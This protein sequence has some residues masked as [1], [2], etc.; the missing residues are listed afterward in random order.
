MLSRSRCF[1]RLFCN[2]I[3]KYQ[4]QNHRENILLRPDS[5]IGSTKEVTC[6]QFLYNDNISQ[7]IKCK[8]SY[9]PGFLKIFDEI[10]VNAADNKQRDPNM[11]RIDISI[12]D[13]N[14]IVVRN[15][16]K[17]IPIQ[18]QPSMNVYIPTLVMGHLLT[19]SNYDDNKKRIVG[20]R[21]GYGAK[22]CN[23]YSKQF[24]ITCF[25]SKE[26]KKFSQTWYDNMS[27]SDPPIIKDIDFLENED[28][29]E[30][31]FIPDLQRF[32]M[33]SI[34]DDVV[35]ILKKRAFDLAG[36][37]NG[38]KVSFNGELINVS[39]FEDYVKLHLSE[40]KETLK[41]F[42]TDRWEIYISQSTSGFEQVS[43][44][45]NIV[46]RIGGS[47]VDYI[48]NQIISHIVNLLKDKIDLTRIRSFH[49]KNHINIFIKC[50][51]ENPSFN[52]QTKEQL[53]SRVSEF[54][55]MCIIPQTF[56]S[57]F[58][59]TSTIPE[60]ILS[61]QKILPS[62][63]EI[64]NKKVFLSKLE[65]ALHAGTNNSSK[66]SLFLTEGDSAK[67]LVVSGFSV[68]G[69]DFYGVF[70]L[71]GKSINARNLSFEDCIKNVEFQ[72]IIKIINLKKN[73]DYS[74]ASNRN[75]LRYGRII[76]F[77][78][79]DLDGIHIKGLVINMFHKFW[80]ELVESGFI[81]TL[82]T[83]L[84]KVRCKGETINFYNKFEFDEWLN[85]SKKKEDFLNY[86][87][88]YYKGLGTSTKEEAKEY[89][90][91]IEKNL[92][93]Y[94]CTNEED[95]LSIK[96][97]FNKNLTFDRKVMIQNYLPSNTSNGNFLSIADFAKNELAE[98]FKYDIK[99]SIPSVVDGLKESQ[100]KIIY[101]MFSKF[102]K[103]EI[104]VNQLSG[105]TAH[106]TLYRHGE[107]FLIS[108]IVKMAQNFVGTGNINLL[109]PI[110]QFGTRAC[111][112][113]DSASGRYIHTSLNPL[114]RLLFPKEDDKLLKYIEEEN[115]IIEPVYYVPIIPTILVN[116]G[117]G[118]AT[119]WS[120]SIF[121]YNPTDII[122]NIRL[123]INGKEPI[124]M[125]PYYRNFKGTIVET[126]KKGTYNINGL[127][128]VTINHLNDTLM[129]VITELP[130][131]IWT[132]DFKEKILQPLY[133]KKILKSYSEFHSNN[134]VHFEII[135]NGKKNVEKGLLGT[136]KK[137]ISTKNMMLFDVNNNLK[138]FKNTGEIFNEFFD[139]RKD[140]YEKRLLNEIN[141]LSKQS[142]Y[143]K[144][145]K[146]FIDNILS[147]R[148]SLV[149]K[150][151]S[152][153]IEKLKLN[154]FSSNPLK[155][156]QED[157]NYLT[158][159]SLYQFTETE[160]EKLKQKIE[161]KK[162]KIDLLK[163]STWK[164]LWNN[165]LNR[166]EASYK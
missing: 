36:T 136:L 80:P 60:S 145:Q 54:G 143:Y 29:T 89:F 61:S 79:Q 50:F 12:V 93:T 14:K 122:N 125:V 135:L 97:A 8:T 27:R 137:T 154:G 85:N 134:D 26:K 34:N 133:E 69:R 113:D 140:L 59:K 153:L 41:C 159:I 42:K 66:C 78:D 76:L 104:K 130:I 32:N 84:V 28:Y 37:C 115:Q 164:D 67:A 116:G 157:Y 107:D 109:Q 11:T 161:E 77:T 74:I 46:T 151:K 25:D 73:I 44:V 163:S 35:S 2:I 53:T 4:K 88:K 95:H 160:N 23:I 5:Y 6:N 98:F 3:T 17:C 10:L 63:K 16:G 62:Q 144:N 166:L 55:S 38:V 91:D 48:A 33:S 92:I 124:D 114:T 123:M 121:P 142:L 70:P 39:N 165:D 15:N 30:V 150:S 132:N 103:D 146:Q 57:D 43:F 24:S 119:G 126:A 96:S 111:G 20:G 1:K 117:K 90:K 152:Q 87:I 106:Y 52:S 131:G 13:S 75:S 86:K 68:I 22:L 139:I 94:T 9:V 138:H 83:P 120:T 147:N 129:V 49:I 156:D 51:I 127:A 155:K 162:K 19:S 82:K 65:D 149:N 112:G 18:F 72:N 100:R 108:T 64:K 7:M 158:N 128:N 58:L 71:K 101:T 56:V 40:M 45:N 118:V 102:E 148:M 21:N 110:G 31:S 99:R 81:Q 141:L 47:H 105:V